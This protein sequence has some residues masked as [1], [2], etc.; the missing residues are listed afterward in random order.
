MTNFTMFTKSQINAKGVWTAGSP[1]PSGG[2]EME[3][4]PHYGIPCE[5]EQVV[6]P[7]PAPEFSC[8]VEY[9]AFLKDR[10]ACIVCLKAKSCR[11]LCNIEISP[12]EAIFASSHI[13][14]E[15]GKAV[16]PKTGKIFSVR[17]A[18]GKRPTCRIRAAE[19]RLHMRGLIDL[20]SMTRKEIVADMMEQFPEYS[21]STFQTV[22]SDGCNKK[23]CKTNGIRRQDSDSEGSQCHAPNGKYCWK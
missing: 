2:N 4:L 21:I 18:E 8:P 7:A 9:S 3:I 11:D 16:H 6:F 14:G 13:K 1:L 22:L 20:G 23:Y 12:N 10:P 17:K 5:L 19:W 15:A